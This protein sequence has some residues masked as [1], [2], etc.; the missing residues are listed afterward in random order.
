MKLDEKYCDGCPFLHFNKEKSSP[1]LYIG[2]GYYVF[3]CKKFNVSLTAY[4][5]QALRLDECKRQ[6]SESK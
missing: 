4:L 2:E 5:D 1:S 3:E 6:E